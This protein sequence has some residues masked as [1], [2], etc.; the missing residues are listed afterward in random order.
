MAEPRSARILPTVMTIAFGSLLLAG[1]HLVDQRDFN[2]NAGAKP[3]LPAGPAV[4]F[5]GPPA[6]VTIRFDTPNPDYEATLADGVRRALARKHDVLF[7]VL[8]L[9]PAAPTPDAQVAAE[10]EAATSG[11]LVAASIVADGAESGQ[12]EQAIRSEPNLK[13]KEVRVLIH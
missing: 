6:L 9:V 11:R 12:V 3:A 1:C 13:V 5:H 4:A 7:T 8:T 2:R 10:S